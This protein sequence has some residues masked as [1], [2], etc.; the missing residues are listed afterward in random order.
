MTCERCGAS[1]PPGT[2]ACTYCGAPTAEAEAIRR[3]AEESA[4]AS[5]RSADAAYQ[6]QS[7]DARVRLTRLARQSALWGVLGSLFCCTPAGVAGLVLGLQAR[8]LATELRES[9]PV[10]AMLGL[11]L[12]ALSTVGSVAFVIW[13]V[14]SVQGDKDRAAHRITELEKQVATSVRAATLDHPTACA[15]AEVYALRNGWSGQSGY[16]LQGFECAGKVAGTAERA[17][18]ED[19]RF[20]A[21]SA[22]PYA[23]FV[24]FKRGDSW[25]VGEMRTTTCPDMLAPPAPAPPAAP[26]VEDAGGAIHPSKMPPKH[27]R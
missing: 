7:A 23:T 10:Q 2:A 27:T 9:P 24:C 12:G 20:R 22:G 15:L 13:A 1:L 25:F 16:S 26:G 21:D 11:A 5:A 14:I 8:R 19:L 18:L 6:K 3:R 17:Q 4:R